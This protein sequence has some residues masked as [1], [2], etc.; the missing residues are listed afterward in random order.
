MLNERPRLLQTSFA[1][2]V[3][4]VSMTF[5]R[6]HVVRL[7][8]GVKMTLSR[9]RQIFVARRRVPVC[10][11][12]VV[13]ARNA[14]IGS[15]TDTPHTCR[16]G[17]SSLSSCM[18]LESLRPTPSKRRTKHRQRLNSN[19]RTRSPSAHTFRETFNS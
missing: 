8:H 6:Q 1:V 19:L 18:R 9:L 17:D 7:L 10:V 5:V 14:P 11:C 15:K 12:R 2:L 16:D 13:L 4:D 3:V